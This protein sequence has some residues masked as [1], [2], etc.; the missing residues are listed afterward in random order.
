[1]KPAQLEMMKL[2][3][4]LGIG[5]IV[6]V[7]VFMNAQKKSKAKH[8]IDNSGGGIVT[9]S[10]N[11]TPHLTAHEETARNYINQYK[12]TYPKE[13]LKAALL[14]SGNAEADV[15]VWLNKYL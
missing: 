4:I 3:L 7:L 9:S 10:S 14:K 11:L 2:V 12:G 5:L 1:M 13:S 15:D 8:A 6:L